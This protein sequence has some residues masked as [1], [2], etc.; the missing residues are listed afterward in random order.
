[1]RMTALSMLLVV[2]FIDARPDAGGAPQV[3]VLCSNGIRQAIEELRPSAERAI[4]TPI[5]I[6]FGS[7]AVLRRRIEGGE[8]F[9]L[10]ILTPQIVGELVKA[11]KIAAGTET[12]VARVNLGAGI[13]RG[14]PKTDISTPDAIRRRLMSARS[15]TY[16]KEGASTPAI[17][18]MLERL[19]I[20]KDL[21]PRTVVQ[22]VS[23]RAAESVAEGQNEI[24]FAPVSEILM[25]K[26]VELLGLFPPEFQ[27]PL[28]MTA[29][30][31][32]GAP[33][34]G[35]AK[36]LITF[37]TSAAAAPAIKASGM[38]PLTGRSGRSGRS[39]RN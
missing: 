31:S 5:A 29:A 8:P 23:G 3:R 2:M 37:L 7:S 6:Q 24:V 18:S 22:T 32:A 19:G 28:V 17:L 30:V 9:D 39:G 10:A 20:R 16:T 34:Q 4:G 15:I 21:E 38:E 35:L 1:M 14:A 13:R 27:Q 25:V 36:A 33:N 12:A 11:G 26:G